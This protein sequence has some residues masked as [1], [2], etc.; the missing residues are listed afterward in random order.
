[1]IENMTRIKND[2][3]K[4]AEYHDYTSPVNI[5]EGVNDRKD[6][7]NE[8]IIRKKRQNYQMTLPLL[9]FRKV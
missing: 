5:E 3:G 6:D 2:E 8:K 4:E 1:M 7:K 9:I